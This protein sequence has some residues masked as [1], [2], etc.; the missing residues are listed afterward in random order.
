MSRAKQ[1][2]TRGENAVVDALRRAGFVHAERRALAGTLDKGDVLGVPGWVFEVKAHDSYA[3]KLGEW[4]GEL[5]REKVNAG[6]EFGV[7]WHRRKGKGSAEDWFVTM[8][9]A[10]FLSILRALEGM[11]DPQSLWQ[12]GFGAE[13][14]PTMPLEG[15]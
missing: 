15:P 9:G 6:A 2:G 13:D 10:E 14:E 5:Q 3:G 8:S 1:K 11:P 12:R 7:V 4:L